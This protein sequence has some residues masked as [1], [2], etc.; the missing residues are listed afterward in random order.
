MRFLIIGINYH[1]ELTGIGKYTG[2]MAEWLVQQ[3]HEVRV[4][5]TPPYYPAWKVQKGYRSW[6]YCSEVIAGVQVYRC[7]VWVPGTPTGFK[8]ILH[9]LSFAIASSLPLIWFGVSWRPGWVLSIEPPLMCAPWA[10]GSAAL[11]RSRSW[12]H[13]QDFEVDAAFELGILNSKWLRSWI[14]AAESWLMRRFDRVSTISERMLIRLGAK[15]ISEKRRV[16]F[17]NW[18][19]LDRI[20]P[21][22]GASPLR[23]EW[24][25]SDSDIVILYSGNMGEKQGLEVLLEA[26]RSMRD[27]ARMVF[28][29]CG[30]GAA[31]SRLV[32]Q[33]RDVVN[34]HFKLLQPLE[35][36][37]DLLNLADIH[38]L[39]Q[40]ANA[41]DLV[42]PSKLTNML[43]SGRPVVVTA[44]AGTQ[45]AELVK[46]CGIVV[47]PGSAS[48]LAG[49][50]MRL[51]DSEDERRKLGKCARNMAEKLW[52]KEQILS[53]L[54]AIQ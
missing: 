33:A 34:I 30:D 42:L 24:G 47:P 18:V 20:R 8:R 14:Q 49:A 25:L 41:A 50:L 38:V 6:L 22:E 46:E 26:A 37:N 7:P 9:L 32:E 52:G 1:P 11:G 53:R 54:F 27:K 13:V 40:R 51:A 44:H 21:L 45:V 43:A 19:E 12:L 23:A 31:R 3:G 15:G 16:L 2:E 35:R 28:V 17:Q 48:A 36:L 29:L 4:V 39:P 10:L 5:T